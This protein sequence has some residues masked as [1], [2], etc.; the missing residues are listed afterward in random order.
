MAGIA[1]GIMTSHI[2][3]IGSVAA[4]GRELA[5]TFTENRSSQTM[6]M[7]GKGRSHAAAAG[8]CD[9]CYGNEMYILF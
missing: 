2:P 9:L 5:P 7:A 8:Y 6:R 1:G 3:T 4:K